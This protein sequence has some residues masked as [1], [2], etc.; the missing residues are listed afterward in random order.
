MR[1]SWLVLVVMALAVGAYGGGNNSGGAQ[2]VAAAISTTPV[3]VQSPTTGTTA[4][5][6]P[7][8]TGEAPGGSGS[9]L[10]VS[11]PVALGDNLWAIA[12]QHL[13]VSRERSPKELSNRRIA[14]YWLRVIT[15]NAHRLASGDPDLIYPGETIVLPPVASA[16]RPTPADQAQTGLPA[17]G[18]TTTT[19]PTT[20]TGTTTTPS[21]STVP[22]TTSR[23][24]PAYD[25]SP[26]PSPTNPPGQGG[27]DEPG[28]GGGKN[29]PKP[30]QQTSHRVVTGDNLWT[31]ARDRLAEA[32]SGGSRKPTNREVADY[33]LRVIEANQ[34]RLVS[35]DPD[36]IYPGETIVLPPFD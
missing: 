10:T 19:S 20:T 31:I 7:K 18:P 12:K 6:T 1:N 33:W 27:P 35:G 3:T 34:G 24:P 25:P 21:T 22:S 8:T 14:A 32:R 26:A 30:G 29:P 5:T 23:R 11:Y 2:L 15:A 4:T 17:P 36:L 13:A 28:S 16:A 9:R